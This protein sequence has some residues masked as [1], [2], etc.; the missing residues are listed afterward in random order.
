MKQKRARIKKRQKCTKE[1]Q[2]IELIGFNF[3]T[4]NVH[5]QYITPYTQPREMYLVDGCICVCAQKCKISPKTLNWEKI[6][7]TNQV[8]FSIGDKTTN[9]SAILFV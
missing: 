2:R 9:V 6:R 4:D 8:P 5:I 7:L 3:L 1:W